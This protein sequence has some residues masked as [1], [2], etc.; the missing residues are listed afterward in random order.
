MRSTLRILIII[1]IVYCFGF[2][3]IT[4]HYFYGLLAIIAS[5]PLLGLGILLLCIALTGTK[6]QSAKNTPSIIWIPSKSELALKEAETVFL[7]ER[8]E[9]VW[10]QV[11]MIRTR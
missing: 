3:I 6:A 10:A 7:Y 11:E 4:L 8:A 1:S 5:A 9:A 2:L